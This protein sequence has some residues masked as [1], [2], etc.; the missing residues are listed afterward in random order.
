M[1]ARR[2]EIQRFHI[3]LWWESGRGFPGLFSLMAFRDGNRKQR[4]IGINSRKLL[5]C[6]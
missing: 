5:Y 6:G 2:K 4:R 1:A 3:G